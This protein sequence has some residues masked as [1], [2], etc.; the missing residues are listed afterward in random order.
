MLRR[1][2]PWR[3]QPSRFPSSGGALHTP[4]WTELTEVVDQERKAGPVYPAAEEVFRAFE[5]TP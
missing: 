4:G 2:T 5:L 3:G 1:R